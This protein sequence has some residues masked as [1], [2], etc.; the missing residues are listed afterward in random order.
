MSL[1]FKLGKNGDCVYVCKTLVAKEI[2]DKD[3]ERKAQRIS[4]EEFLSKFPANIA[5]KMEAKLNR[6]KEINKEIKTVNAECNKLDRMGKVYTTS[7]YYRTTEYCYSFGEKDFYWRN[8]D[9]IAAIEEDI[10]E[11]K[12]AR[13][14]AQNRYGKELESLYEKILEHDSKSLTIYLK[15]K[16]E[17]T[18]EEYEEIK[19]RSNDLYEEIDLLTKIVSLQKQEI[20]KTNKK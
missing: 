15:D 11:T 10:D 9:P 3:F 4:V 7:G 2:S 12:E 16:K 20:K 17:I 1:F 18:Q 14:Y 5:S 6:I 19:K 8:C 13:E